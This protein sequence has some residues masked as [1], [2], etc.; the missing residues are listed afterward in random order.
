MFPLA[1]VGISAGSSLLGGILQSNSA[2]TAAKRQFQR[3]LYMSNTSYQRAMKD[4]RK[5]GLNPML[6]YQQGGASTPN[7]G[8]AQVPN[9]MEGIP[10]AVNTG[11]AAKKN[12]AEVTNIESQT[13]K[14][15]ADTQL[16][17]AMA[18]KTAADTELAGA[19]TRN[20]S[21]DTWVKEKTGDKT[22]QD[23]ANAQQDWVIKNHQMN[24]LKE[25][26]KIAQ[27]QANSAKS[28]TII[29]WAAAEAAKLEGN[30]DKEEFGEWTRRINRIMSSVWGTNRA[31]NHGY[32]E[33]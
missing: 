32:R 8:Q 23:T 28:R 3:E 27:A 15:V 17:S 5:A 33:N 14:N 9:I 30:I 13:A 26:I 31:L 22:H 19:Q 1:A 20:T 12:E 24:L 10:N 4:M 29:D 18:V 11:L 21:M 16:S 6:A 2:K 25:Q 7:V